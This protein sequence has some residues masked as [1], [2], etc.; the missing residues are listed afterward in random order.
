[1]NDIYINVLSEFIAAALLAL[2]A[3]LRAKFIFQLARANPRL[4]AL[5]FTVLAVLLAGVSVIAVMVAPSKVWA[6]AIIVM[7]WLVF[8][9]FSWRELRQFWDVGVKGADVRI[10]RGIDYK[11][12]LELCHN[13]LD[14]L[15][16]GAS[17]LTRLD[18]FDKAVLRCRPDK[19][20]RLLLLSPSDDSLSRAARRAGRLSDVAPVPRRGGPLAALDS[21]D[22]HRA[23]EL[24][25]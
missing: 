8:I 4:P 22:V 12:A 13:Y 15:G 23:A 25:G 18:E 11:K 19:P 16:V 14:F 2:L 6:S 3:W 1:M 5:T 9:Y 21:A 7:T 10:D 24:H 20:I 17:K